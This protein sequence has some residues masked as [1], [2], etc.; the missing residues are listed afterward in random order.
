M[1]AMAWIVPVEQVRSV[2]PVPISSGRRRVLTDLLPQAAGCQGP[3]SA[4]FQQI[5]AEPG[6]KINMLFY[7]ETKD[8]SAT[9]VWIKLYKRDL[10]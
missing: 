10:D 1:L 6:F 8:P 3:L 5:A 9:H 4:V 7:S 2:H